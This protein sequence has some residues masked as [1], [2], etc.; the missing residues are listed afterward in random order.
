MGVVDVARVVA[1]NLMQ[2]G[3]ARR[4][5][6]IVL[7]LLEH[8][9]D[10]VVLSEW[11]WAMGGQM[12]AVLAEHGLGH[13]SIARLGDGEHGVMVASRVEL[14]GRDGV[15]RHPGEAARNAARRRMVEVELVGLDLAVAAV[16]VPCEGP[17]RTAVLA[18]VL[19]CARRR[20]DGSCLIV[21]DFNISARSGAVEMQ[22]RGVEANG[23]RALGQ[24]ATLG[25][26]D[27]W[28]RGRAGAEEATWVSHEGRGYR[29]D[30]AWAS[31]RCAARVV[32]CVYSHAERE[33][34]LSDHSL[35]VVD[36]ENPL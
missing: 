25:Y 18:D 22:P 19:E 6:G 33:A 10:V 24:L 5:P 8:G 28:A 21:G 27:A 14:V 12:A 34:G 23:W 13:Q 32:Q 35:I 3:G 30:H 11:K 15:A 16:H 31:Q 36:V 20:R 7:A 4:T 17:G 26:V 29:I 2:G 1:W 9:A